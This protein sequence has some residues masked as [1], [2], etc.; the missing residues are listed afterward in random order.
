MANIYAISTISMALRDLLK[1][2]R[3]R[4]PDLQN[5]GVE[6]FL[7]NNFK[8]ASS[9]PTT[10]FLSIYMYRTAVSTVRRNLP[11]K[12]DSNGNKYN[13]PLPLDIHYMFTPWA[14]KAEVQ[15]ALL[16][17]AMRKLEDTPTLS[18]SLLNNANPAHVPF[19]P[20]ESVDLVFEPITIADLLYVWEVGKPNVQ[21]SVTYVARA[22]LIDSDVML[23]EGKPVQTR[24]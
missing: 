8:D 9:S 5:A 14:A 17:W 3:P 6:L 23:T 10:P 4:E 13:P 11:P 16:A 1:S 21:V 22:V 18:A 2:A 15:Q 12:I 19:G 24:Q 20:E 7:A